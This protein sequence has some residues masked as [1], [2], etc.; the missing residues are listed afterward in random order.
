MRSAVGTRNENILLPTAHDCETRSQRVVPKSYRREGQ[1][2]KTE[3]EFS[4][5][6]LTMIHRESHD[7]GKFKMAVFCVFFKGDRG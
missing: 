1:P 3:N 7:F 5:D 6:R 4:H 2:R